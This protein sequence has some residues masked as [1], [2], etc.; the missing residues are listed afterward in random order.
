M[1]END[2]TTHA[3][4]GWLASIGAGGPD[5]IAVACGLSPT[6][7]R[8]RLRRLERD[9][10]TRHVGLLRGAPA[11]HLLTRDGLR[12]SGRPELGLV[13]VSAA[14]FAHQLAVAR[15]AA[16][17]GNGHGPIGGERE[18]RALERAEG[19]PIA[20]AEIGYGPDGSVALHRPDLVCWGGSLPLAIE[21]ELTV[22]APLRLRAII[23]GW[24]RSR[25]V[26]GVVYYASPH[27]ARALAA[28]LRS[29]QAADRVAILPLDGAG[30]LPEFDRRAV[31][32]RDG[33]GHADRG[34]RYAPDRRVP[35]QARRSVAVR[36]DSTRARRP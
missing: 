13:T 26:A 17:L 28:A 30:P 22:K 34:I 1:R 36:I 5:E 16:A 9:G 18:L 31:P 11:L 33:G 6:A 4:L 10:L 12:F 2:P 20:S 32:G 29:E 35:S 15:I 24:A 19:R 27:A 8:S 14:S 7:A 23:R 3:I 21:V 25:L